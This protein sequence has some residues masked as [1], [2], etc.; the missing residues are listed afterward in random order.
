M[1]YYAIPITFY[2]LGSAWIWFY[3]IFS[4]YIL[5]FCCSYIL[6]CVFSDV[7]IGDRE[8]VLFIDTQP[9]MWS[10][11]KIDNIALYL[12]HSWVTT[13]RIAQAP[14]WKCLFFSFSFCLCALRTMP[15]DST[16][17]VEYVIR[18]SSPDWYVV[19]NEIHMLVPRRRKPRPFPFASVNE[20]VCDS[21]SCKNCL[22]IKCVKCAQLIWCAR[23]II[24]ILLGIHRLLV[25]S[26]N[27]GNHKGCGR[28]NC[29]WAAANSQPDQMHC[30]SFRPNRIRT[31]IICATHILLSLRQP[32]SKRKTQRMCVWNK[33]PFICGVFG[34]G[35]PNAKL[36]CSSVGGF[37]LSP[38]M[39]FAKPTATATII[40]RRV[41]MG[42]SNWSG[43]H[44]AEVNFN[45]VNEMV[46]VEFCS[47]SIF[48]DGWPEWST[49]DSL[50]ASTEQQ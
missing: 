50:V 40:N 37:H 7:S 11:D 3:F 35:Q 9:S 14:I 27:N 43:Q 47:F 31:V 29:T 1:A 28:P 44:D 17:F 12:L 4:F 5:F 32:A 10:I 41:W 48:G 21:R 8:A 18:P 34:E 46:T 20:I 6:Y 38:S 33:H 23:M 39:N 45:K 25:S 36:Q 24:S 22:I 2:S 26:I 19:A 13:R 16:T 30:T 49:N 42:R 15:F